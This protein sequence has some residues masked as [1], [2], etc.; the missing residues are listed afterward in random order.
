MSMSAAVVKLKPG[1]RRPPMPK[2]TSFDFAVMALKSEE[3]R[4]SRM[5]SHPA[6]ESSIDSVNTYQGAVASVA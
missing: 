2:A 6:A 3:G 4:A 5:Y 1:P